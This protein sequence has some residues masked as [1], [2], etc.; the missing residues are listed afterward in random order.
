MSRGFAAM[1]V[2][3]LCALVPAAGA[4]AD[5]GGAQW[6]SAP[7]LAPAPPSG[8]QPSPFPVPIGYVG[9]IEFWAP[10]RGVLITSGNSVVS[11]GLYAYDGV[12][13]HQ[14]ST[15]CGGTDGRIA[16]AGPD[17]FWTISD[18]RPG[19][20][21]P[22]GG[23][24]ALQDVSLCHFQNGQ[25]LASYALPLDQPNSY[26]PMNAAA[27]ASPTDCWFGGA[28]D[29]NGAFHLH[30]DGATLSV[31]DSPV[32]HEIASMAVL[33]GEIFE[34]VQLQPNDSYG[35]EDPNHPPLLHL[36]APWDPGDPFHSLFPIDTQNPA[37]GDF[38]PPLPEYGSDED[39]NPVAPVT[40]GGLALSSDS[41]AGAS[42]P[43]MWA[44][45]GPDTTPPPTTDQGSAH[46]VVVRYAD[47]AWTQVVPNLVSLPGDDIP[48]GTEGA[49]PSAQDVAAEPGQSA[50]W[51][52]VTSSTVPDNEAH[53]D[54]VALDG[55]SS[56]SVTDQDALGT[57]QG[58]GPR[59]AASAISCPAVHDCWVATTNGWLFHLT[60]GTQLPQDTD[61]N[62]AGVI[63]YRPPDDGVPAV[64]P[65]QEVAQ[66]PAQPPPPT[67]QGTKRVRKVHKKAKPLVTHMSHPQLEHRTTLV[68]SFTLTAKAHVQ[69][70]AKAHGRVVAETRLAVMAPGRRTLML[71][72]DVHHWPTALV[73]HAVPVG[74]HRGGGGGGGGGGG[75]GVIST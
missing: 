30:W 49:T 5:E 59:G 36:I 51:I 13:W 24:G 20:V 54:R 7:A 63:T 74:A 57:A 27:C 16:W 28:L 19:Q 4:M 10:N 1:A 37:C 66:Q 14:L 33:R 68:M 70:I 56:A 60:D 69:L 38:C 34:S 21:L 22:N 3:L 73:L 35:T 11:E 48:V 47:G 15:V 50:A 18:Q 31:V 61:P 12:S 53:V 29:S 52:A 26:R 55:T 17:E 64:I 46:P 39:G 43:Q 9:D 2:A 75:P 23:V 6:V 58:V 67:Q 42:D 72:L 8:G 41:A 65:D 32:D 25:V 71:R 40:L 45:A 62:F 44:A